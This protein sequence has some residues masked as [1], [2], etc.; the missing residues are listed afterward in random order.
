MEYK[1]SKV[2]TA[3]ISCE[4]SPGVFIYFPCSARDIGTLLPLPP[5][6]ALA[7]AQPPS[8]APNPL[9]RQPPAP[10]LTSPLPL[11]SPAPCPSPRLPA[12]LPYP[13]PVLDCFKSLVTRDLFTH[14]S[15][16]GQEIYDCVIV[17]LARQPCRHW[18]PSHYGSGR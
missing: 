12:A 18:L 11:A 13:P 14:S 16:F 3:P 6:H 9:P 8:A 17:C 2:E 4:K 5:P 7:T 10:R 1:N 15:R